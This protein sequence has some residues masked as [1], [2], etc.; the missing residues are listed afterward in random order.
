[1]DCLV[2]I[3]SI[4]DTEA[5][6]TE[7]LAGHFLF[8]NVF[9]FLSWS[10]QK[11][12][13]VPGEGKRDQLNSSSSSLL[14]SALS[15]ASEKWEAAYLNRKPPA[16]STPTHKQPHAHTEMHPNT[17][18]I[19]NQ[20]TGGEKHTTWN[21]T[22]GHWGSKH[23]GFIQ[24]LDL[25]E[26]DSDQLPPPSSTLL[27]ELFKTV[28]RILVPDSCVPIQRPAWTPSTS[29]FDD[30]TKRSPKRDS[31][32]YRGLPVCITFVTPIS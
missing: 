16:T 7:P 20:W 6:A 24:T 12:L 31:L 2:C 1:M 10:T 11:L 27:W 23:D 28:P 9:C 21:I 5:S 17:Q 22:E 13:T 8:N 29:A 25:K 32:V 14:H 30:Q 15:S 19:Y 3:L 26:E 4:P 18:R